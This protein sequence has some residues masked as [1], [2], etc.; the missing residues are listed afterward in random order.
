[1]NLKILPFLAWFGIG[2]AG[3]YVTTQLRP[4]IGSDMSTNLAL[5]AFLLGGIAA[6]RIKERLG[7]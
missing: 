2:I 7:L 4:I 1:M 5:L 3:T 6:C